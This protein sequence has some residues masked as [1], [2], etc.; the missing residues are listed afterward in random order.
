[1]SIIEN[2]TENNVDEIF[3]TMNYGPAPEQADYGEDWL[4]QHKSGFELFIDG[5]WQAPV[6]T[7]SMLQ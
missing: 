2:T 1:M 6:A 7:I 5:Q 4:A 3:Q